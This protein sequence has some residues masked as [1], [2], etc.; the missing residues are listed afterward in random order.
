MRRAVEEGLGVDG[1]KKETGLLDLE[2]VGWNGWMEDVNHT[3]SS[4]PFANRS[5]MIDLH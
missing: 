1:L 2:L 4:L 3:P 5:M